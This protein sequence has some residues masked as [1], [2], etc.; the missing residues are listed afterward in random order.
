MTT[1]KRLVFF[2]NWVDP[3]AEQSLGKHPGI[4]LVK[5]EYRKDPATVWPTM[6]AAHGYQISPRG[7]LQEPWFGDEQLLRRCPK[8]LAITSTG[9]G[10]DM[11]DVEACTKAGVIVCN[12]SGS[13]KEAVAEHA[14]GMILSLSKK[15][16]LANRTMQRQ[17]GVDRFALKGSDIVGKTVGIVGIGEIGTRLAELCKV[18]QITV[19]AYDPYVGAA[20]VEARGARKVVLSELLSRSDFVSVHCPRSSETM[21]M[22]AMR[23]FSAMKATAYFINTA[24]GGIHNEDDLAESVRQKIIAGA[25]VDVFLKEPPPIDHPLL[26]LDNVIATPHTAGVTVE[27]LRSMATAAAEQW[28]DI[29]AGR[30]PPRL[31]NPDA[32][33]RYQQRWQEQF[34]VRIPDLSSDFGKVAAGSI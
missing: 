20:D 24:R 13:N 17:S 16:A 4:E 18:F 33:P 30:L 32:W 1:R 31:V 23:E 5:L 11:I 2:E 21:N 34:S 28:I 27:A 29:L 22:F 25:A 12:Q 14:L 8:L 19:L 10:F 7:E 9:A 3:V 26:R 15:I 6:S